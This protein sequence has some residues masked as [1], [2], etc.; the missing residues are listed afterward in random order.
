MNK[1]KLKQIINDL[2]EITKEIDVSNSFV[3]EQAVKIYISESI[4]ESKKENIQEM[5][6]NKEVKKDEPITERQIQKLHDLGL[7]EIPK[8]LTKTEA[9]TMISENIK[10]KKI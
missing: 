6:N 5:K 9:W 7:K 1:E 3:L 2:L 8:G 4:N 10:N